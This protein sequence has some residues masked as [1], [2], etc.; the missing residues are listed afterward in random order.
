VG[1]L[2]TLMQKAWPFLVGCLLPALAWAQEPPAAQVDAFP[3][4]PRLLWD[5]TAALV[6]MPGDWGSRQWTGFAWGAAAVLA[7]GLALDRPVDRAV[8]RNPSPSLNNAARNV[9]QLGGAG[10]LVLI[11][12]GY[13]G[14]SLLGKDQ[15]RSLWADA[16]IA[17]VL[18]RGTAFTVQ[19]ATGRATPSANRGTHAFQP[20]S[21]NDSF[22]SGHASQA[23]AT[24]S[25]IAMHAD[26]PWVGAAAYGLA[27]LVGLARLETRDHF[28]SDVLAG[29][30]IGTGIG[31]AV[32][33]VNQGR[34]GG[35]AQVSVA[36]VLAPGY[37]GLSLV[38]RF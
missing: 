13:L 3:A 16:G 35:Q 26:S 31:R 38:A 30:L 19:L 32:V 12:G 28:S 36:P 37:R 14:S 7:T 5:D 25:V 27:G 1:Y 22:P 29:A 18:A 20:F 10:G 21:S 17:T 24:A 34:R 15:A 23:F 6:R 4:L 11:G 2:E 9:A 8:L 33:R